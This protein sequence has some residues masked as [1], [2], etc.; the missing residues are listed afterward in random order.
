MERETA[1][2]SSEQSS[3]REPCQATRL[4]RALAPVVQLQSL[5]GNRG[6]GALL[7]GGVLQSKLKIGK[8]GDKYEQEADR[9]AE[10]VMRMPEPLSTVRPYRLR[11]IQRK[12]KECEEEEARHRPAEVGQEESQRKPDSDYALLKQMPGSERAENKTA[13]MLHAQAQPEVKAEEHMGE[14]GGSAWAGNSLANSIQNVQ[15]AGQPLSTELRAFFEPRFG[16]D[17]SSVRLHTGSVATKAARELHAQAFTVGRHIYFGADSY[18]PQT[19]QGKRLVGHELTHTIQQ[20]SAKMDSNSNRN[21]ARP[22]LVMPKIQCKKEDRS[23]LQIIDFPW[24]GRINTQ[25]TGL[26]HQPRIAQSNRDYI[27]PDLSLGDYVTVLGKT[28]MNWLRV[29]RTTDGESQ[30]G[31]VD[32]RY[33]DFVAQKEKQPREKGKNGEEEISKVCGPDVTAWLISQMRDNGNGSLARHLRSLNSSWN[34]VDWADAFIEWW[35]LV[36]TGGPW[37]FKTRLGGDLTEPFPDCRRNCSGKL[38]SITLKNVCMTYEAPANIH[39]GYVGRMAGFSE[40][41]L[42]SGAA[43]AQTREGRGEIADDPRDVEAIK[44]GF[45]LFNQGNPSA[46]SAVDLTAN[47]YKKL[48]KGDGDPEGCDAC[49]AAYSGK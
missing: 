41:R 17:F 22:S 18:R 23:V 8:P 12:C 38:W 1:V 26:H 13:L 2:K 29:Q 45:S 16:A 3:Q 36:R 11:G 48:P 49:S 15:G 24:T 33:V 6:V 28:S 4:D 27:R 31:F 32:W 14:A 30:G 39:Y 34:P 5:I 37:D 42:L 10:D 40:S 9:V 7:Q 25:G 44:V 20:G 46:F 43:D 19:G 35:A 47:H 21:S